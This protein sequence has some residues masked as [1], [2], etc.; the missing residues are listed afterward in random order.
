MSHYTVRMR[1]TRLE[2]AIAA[3]LI[4]YPLST[5]PRERTLLLFAV[6]LS[7]LG[8]V[9]MVTALLDLALWALLPWYPLQMAFIVLFAAGLLLPILSMALGMCRVIIYGD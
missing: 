9:S 7:L 5:T 6:R 4:R 2:H 1:W 8:I 3:K